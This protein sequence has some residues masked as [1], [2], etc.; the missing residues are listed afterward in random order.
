MAQA[1]V[2]I[3]HDWYPIA[4]LL[5]MACEEEGHH[6]TK[7]DTVEDTLAALQS[8]PHPLVVVAERD[9][10]SLHPSGPF[11]HIIHEHPDLYGRHRYIAMHAWKI[12]EDERGLMDE[13]GIPL[14][15]VPFDVQA[16][17]QMVKQ[18][19]SELV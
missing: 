1:H 6:I 18:F 7:T 17:M 15:A 12:P 5:A 11:F 4:E 16:M 19:A 2:L 13:M 14:V 9:H 10:S 3:F 8:S